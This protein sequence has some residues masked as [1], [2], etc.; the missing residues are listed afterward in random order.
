MFTKNGRIS[1][2]KVMVWLTGSAMGV[3][4]GHYIIMAL[5]HN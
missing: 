2:S 1:F 4:A 5:L 3:I